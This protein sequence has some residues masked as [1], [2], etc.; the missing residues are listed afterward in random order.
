MHGQDQ[1]QCPMR[2]IPLCLL[3]TEPVSW[4]VCVCV[5]VFV[6][7]HV[8]VHVSNQVERALKK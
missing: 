7:A 3:L 6:C 4:G 8:S 5:C 1:A 2:W